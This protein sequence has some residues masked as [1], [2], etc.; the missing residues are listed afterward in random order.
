MLSLVDVLVDL[1]SLILQFRMAVLSYCMSFSSL[2]GAF[3][4]FIRLSSSALKS[5]K[6]N[7]NVI[8]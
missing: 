3:V 8:G 2:F 7:V 6:I 5:E 1:Y 4:I